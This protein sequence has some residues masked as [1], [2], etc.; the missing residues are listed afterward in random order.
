MAISQRVQLLSDNAYGVSILAEYLKNPKLIEQLADEIKKLNSLTEQEEKKASAARS[1]IITYDELKK[2]QE[3]LEADKLAHEKILSD[4]EQ[5]KIIHAEEIQ[6]Q[7]DQLAENA[8]QLDN[9]IKIHK[10]NVADL[11]DSTNELNKKHSS[12]ISELEAEK[13]SLNKVAEANQAKSVE[14]DKLQKNL[15]E[16]ADKLQ[17]LLTE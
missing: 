4:F 2:Q 9:A 10:K 8:L 12:A 11:Q 17:N 13:T 5:V 1:S 7:K 14:L 6:K 16:K 15:K 3:K